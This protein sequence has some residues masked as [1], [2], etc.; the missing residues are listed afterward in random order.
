MVGAGVIRCALS[1]LTLEC[2]VVQHVFPCFRRRGA[3][4]LGH[5][6]LIVDETVRL[7]GRAGPVTLGVLQR[8]R[9][10]SAHGGRDLV[11]E[12]VGD[13]VF[14]QESVSG[15]R[16]IE[17]RLAAPYDVSLRIR[18]P[19]A[20]HAHCELSALAGVVGLH[21]NAILGL[22]PDLESIH[23]GD[24]H[25]AGDGGDNAQFSLDLRRC[26]R[27]HCRCHHDQR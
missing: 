14:D 10:R 5:Q 26:S 17:H 18:S 6:A 21:I 1:Y 9:L 16:I 23:C 25:E 19:L 8:H 13:F 20:D 2:R 7:E 12:L 22:C 3:E 11:E 27:Q 4:T 24:A 15:Q